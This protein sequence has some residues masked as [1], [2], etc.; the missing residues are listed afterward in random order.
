MPQ[1]YHC[2]GISCVTKIRVNPPIIL[3]NVGHV[4]NIALSNSAEHLVLKRCHLVLAMHFQ[5]FSLVLAFFMGG[6]PEGFSVAFNTH[7][8]FHYADLTAYIT[9]EN[10]PIYTKNAA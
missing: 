8:H 5:V 10:P 7:Q 9:D 4:Q 1:H 2:V 6:S 3:N